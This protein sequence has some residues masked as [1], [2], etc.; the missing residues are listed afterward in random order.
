MSEATGGRRELRKAQTRAEVRQTAQRLFAE[1][2]FDAVTIADVAAAAP[3]LQTR[4]A[5]WTTT[6]A[7]LAAD[8]DVV[9]LPALV[10][11]WADAVWI[12][13]SPAHPLLRAAADTALT[14]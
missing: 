11:S 12:D 9:D 6:V 3:R 4:P 2:G 13:W 10:R 1:R 8:L 5:R 14:G 7:D